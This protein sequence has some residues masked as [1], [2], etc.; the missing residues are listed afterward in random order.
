MFVN[1]FANLV[2]APFRIDIISITIVIEDYAENNAVVGEEIP[3]ALQYSP[4]GDA[5]IPY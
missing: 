5:I 4:V 3:I 1:Y 2:T